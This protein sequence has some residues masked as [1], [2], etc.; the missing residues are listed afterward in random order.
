MYLTQAED[1]GRSEDRE[2]ARQAWKVHFLFFQLLKNIYLL[3]RKR[4]RARAGGGVRGRETQAESVLSA[5]PY[6]GL[7]PTALRS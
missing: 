6:V 5:K 1:S 7:D 3:Q 4:E 2:L